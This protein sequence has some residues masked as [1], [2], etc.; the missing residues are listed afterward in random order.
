MARP[1]LFPVLLLLLPACSWAWG[2]STH[3][4][5]ASCVSEG[6]NLSLLFG[7]MLPD[8]NAVIRDNAAEAAALKTLVHRE[9]DRLAPSALKTGVATHNAEWGADYYAHLIYSENPPDCYSIQK[10]RQLHN[11]F[12]ITISQAEDVIEMCVDIQI[13]LLL[14]PSWGALVERAAN[15]SGEGHEQAMVDAYAGELAARVEGL[16][17]Q[18]AEDDIRM[19]VRGHK[20]LA[21]TLGRQLRLGD[22]EIH[23]AIPP[24]LSLYL[25]C[26]ADKAA[27]FY[28]RGLEI[29]QDC[30]TEMDRICAAIKTHMPGVME[31]EHEEE[32]ENHGASEA[33]PND[34]VVDF[35]QAFKQVHENPLLQGLDPAF[36]AFVELLNP[37][38]ADLNGAFDVNTSGG[39]LKID[40]KG[41]GIPDAANELGLLARLLNHPGDFPCGIKSPAL[42][43]GNALAAWKANVE[44]L[45]RDI[46]PAAALVDAVVPGLKPILTGYLTLGDGTFTVKSAPTQEAPDAPVVASG[47][48]SFGLVAA[49]FATLNTMLAREIGSGFT[50]PGLRREDYHTLPALLPEG[51]VDGDGFSNRDEYEQFASGSCKAGPDGENQS[52]TPTIT[53]LEA[54]LDAG[55]RPGRE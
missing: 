26:D 7:A 43:H 51:D 45:D 42:N 24:V 53:Y 54:A 28:H 10:I 31:E 17:A 41:N 44:Q 29:T 19:A 4:Y 30:M 33:K 12:G 36:A 14:G 9:F 34:A 32:E 5:I 35:Y 39:T 49:M 47:H 18:K 1:S 50:N 21:A 37:A 38:T 52:D 2:P 8:C 23:T 25:E 3:A 20:S 13:R 46:G 40:V 48:G 6:K 22:E 16:S 27:F 15:A 55:I 11:E